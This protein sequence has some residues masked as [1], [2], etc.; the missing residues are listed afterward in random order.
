M[1]ALSEPQQIPL[2]PQGETQ[3]SKCEIDRL[4]S[5][6]GINDCGVVLPSMAVS[7]MYWLKK[8]EHTNLTTNGSY[9][10]KDIKCIYII[11]HTNNQTDDIPM[12]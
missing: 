8:M 6:S 2:S 7:Y 9:N 10:S 4:I 12:F 5:A 1:S 11:I 3:M